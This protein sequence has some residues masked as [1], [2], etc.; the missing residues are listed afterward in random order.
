MSYTQDLRHTRAAHVAVAGGKGAALGELL[1]AGVPVPPGFVVTTA[2]FNHF[3]RAN[4]LGTPS[5]ESIIAAALPADLQSQ[6]TAAYTA[7]NV[8][9]VAVRSSATAED[10]AAHAWAGQLES[11]VPTGANSLITNIK[12]CWASLYSPRAI[13][14]REQAGLAGADV[15]VAVVVQALVDSEHAGIAFSAHP[16]TG[17]TEHIV[18][19]AV[20][21]LG[22][23]AVGGHV[24][25]HT[26]VLSKAH[27]EIV[28]L[29]EGT[30]DKMLVRGK[31]QQAE[32]RPLPKDAK[33]LSPA[34]LQELAGHVR[35]IEQHFGAPMDV[36]W[37]RQHDTFY[38]VQSRPITTL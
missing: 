11:F 5:A 38:I 32:W 1:A 17:S 35:R 19:E 23:A 37:A 3:L 15:S 22:E 21:G 10:G 14:Y 26:Y 18:V 36:E 27:G 28:E 7:L 8:P 20:H 25:P 13:T 4:T 30:Q 34:V 24:T 6:I 9:H 16:V 2:A 12:K 33:K 29:Y 31:N